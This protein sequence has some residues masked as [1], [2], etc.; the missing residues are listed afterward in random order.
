MNTLPYPMRT[1][2]WETTLRCNARCEFCGSGCGDCMD[3]P[4]ELTTDEIC[5]ALSDVAKAFDPHDIMLNITGGEPLLRR[6]LFTVAEFASGLGFPWGMVTNGSLITPE[7]IE[8]MRTAGMKT[9]TVSID[10]CKNT[11]E[12]LRRL[13]GS[14]ERIID[15]LKMICREGFCDH[16]QVTTV[17]NRKNIGELEELR[18]LLLDIGLDS[19]RVIPA[20]PIGRAKDNGDILPD[21]ECMVKYL[22]FLEKYFAD[23]ELPVVSSCAHYFGDREH[24][25]RTSCFE[26]GA[27]RHVASILWNGDIFVCPNVERRSELIQ[28][29]VRRDKLS[30]VWKSGF[31]FF[32]RR[33]RTLSQRCRSCYYKDNCLGDSLHTFDLDRR[34]QRFCIRDHYNDEQT[35]AY[36]KKWELFQSVLSGYRAERAENI[37][38]ISC[39]KPS[40]GRVIFSKRASDELRSI[41]EWGESS[42]GNRIEQIACLY[43]RQEDSLFAVSRVIEAPFEYADEMSGVF[44]SATIDSALNRLNELRYDDPQIKMLG[45]VHSHPEELKMTLSEADAELHLQ[46]TEKTGM[47]L[48]MLI[49]PQKK[50]LKAYYGREFDLS[51]IYVDSSFA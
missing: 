24:R 35:S 38:R 23:Y 33:G 8:K 47:E 31:G 11:H 44:T 51:E 50:Q 42:S 27:G 46:L 49:N 25:L 28:G 40:A 4:D 12:A 3:F 10:G 36:N 34:E 32:R 45:F 19:W 16:V 37:L 1:L 43:G 17:V 22:E 5:S 9:L 20:D 14:F 39:D 26:C 29:N 41:F 7:I 15:S 18:R 13:P 30:E 21:R 48:S 2:F 6:D